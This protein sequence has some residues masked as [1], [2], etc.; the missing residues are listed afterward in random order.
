MKKISLELTGKLSDGSVVVID[1]EYAVGSEVYV[2]DETG[3]KAPIFDGDHTLESGDVFVTVDGKITEIKPKMEDT[4]VE[5]KV[6][7]TQLEETK[8]EFVSKEEFNAL[9]ESFNTFKAEFSKEIFE[10]IVDS[11]IN[12]L[13]K[14][15]PKEEFKKVEPKD[16]KS[17]ILSRIEALNG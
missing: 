9:L 17:F 5:Q 6:E 8:V 1:G 3:T 2:I 16:Y 13:V 10:A 12:G 15:E 4:Q 7:E 11:K 14:E